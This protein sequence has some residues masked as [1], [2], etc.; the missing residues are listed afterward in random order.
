MS[1]P[2]LIRKRTGQIVEM[3]QGLG[4]RHWQEPEEV[5][6]VVQDGKIIASGD[7]NASLFL[8]EKYGEGKGL[9]ATDAQILDAVLHDE[10]V[11][12]Y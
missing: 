11:F 5:F 8:S 1:Q 9:E 2:K 10:S 4:E 3:V 12:D 7:V 6:Y